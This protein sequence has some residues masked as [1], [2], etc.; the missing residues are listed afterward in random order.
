MQHRPPI[1]IPNFY[2]YEMFQIV[3]RD[4]F[5]ILIQLATDAECPKTTYG[6]LAEQVGYGTRSMNK[7][8]GSIWQTLYEFQQEFGKDIPYLTT[9]V[10]NK[11]TK[12]PTYFKSYSGWS[13]KEI[14][15]AQKDVYAFQRWTDVMERILK[16]SA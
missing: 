11:N 5:P 15:A 4:A 14:A 12:V 3:A 9:I 16:K 10:V 7:P 2:G 6:K 8:L 13:N 1:T